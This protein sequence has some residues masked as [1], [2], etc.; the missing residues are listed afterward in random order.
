[1]M[2]T[3]RTQ[4]L[5]LSTSLLLI[6]Q[7]GFAQPEIQW[8][9]FQE[10][11]QQARQ[12]HKKLLVDVYTDWCRWCK[13]MDQKTFQHPDVVQYVNDNYIAVRFNAESDQDIHYRGRTY[14]LVRNGKNSHHELAA[15][16]MRGRLNFPTVV[17]LDESLN[18][19]QPIPGYQDAENFQMIL[20]YFAEDFFRRVPWDKYKSQVQDR[21]MGQPVNQR[22][23][24]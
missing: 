12:E 13:V 14:S 9:S 19:I 1:M 10:G 17:F 18:V 5:F 2:M 7:L 4:I 24:N 23:R 3:M 21:V 16:M 15:E 22:G 20:S 11:L 8:V 6:A